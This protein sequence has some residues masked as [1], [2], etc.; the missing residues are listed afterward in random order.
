[1]V[2]SVVLFGVGDVANA[3]VVRE[4]GGGG[5]GG[6]GNTFETFRLRRGDIIGNTRVLEIQEDKV[7]VEVE[8]F[9]LAERR[10]LE[11]PRGDEGGAS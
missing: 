9:G 3:G 2:S 6:G 1:M 11:L 7:I 5:G 8:E 10:V 4:G